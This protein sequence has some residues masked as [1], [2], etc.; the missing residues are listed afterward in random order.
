LG[1]CAGT[2]I[3]VSAVDLVPELK[4][5]SRSALVIVS[6]IGGFLL[7]AAFSLFLPPV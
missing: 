4:H 3:Y 6:M 7:I 5:R 1:L 2:F